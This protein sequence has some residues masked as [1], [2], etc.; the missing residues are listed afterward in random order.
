MVVN[1]FVYGTL[2]DDALVRTLTGRR[3][4][5]ENAVLRGYRKVVVGAPYPYVVPDPQAI[6]YGSL[7]CD[8]DADALDALDRYEEEG[9]LYRR[10]DVVVD[11]PDGPI[12][13]ATY[14]GIVG[15]LTSLCLTK[16]SV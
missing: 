8:V 3:F 7:L 1:L 13:S 5:R 9:H 16:P 4:R 14:V 12:A 6:T 2:G 10:I 11:G 15:N